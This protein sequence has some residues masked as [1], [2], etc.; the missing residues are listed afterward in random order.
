MQEKAH[1]I[2]ARCQS[3]EAFSVQRRRKRFYKLA[4]EGIH[5]GLGHGFRISE[6]RPA[7]G[8]IRVQDRLSGRQVEYGGAVALPPS[9]KLRP[10]LIRRR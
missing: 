6:V 8:R 2:E 9:P 7:G 10:E 5:F 4:V 3:S 1:D